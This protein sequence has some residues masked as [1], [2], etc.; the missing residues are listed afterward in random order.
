MSLQTFRMFHSVVVYCSL[1][2]VQ[3]HLAEAR[4]DHV[5]ASNIWLCCHKNIQKCP[6]VFLKML[7]FLM[8]HKHNWKIYKHLEKYRYINTLYLKFF[9]VSIL[10]FHSTDTPVL[11]L[12]F[13]YFYLKQQFVTCTMVVLQMTFTDSALRYCIW[14]AES[15][16]ICKAMQ[17][18]TAFHHWQREHVQIA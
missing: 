2:Q 4:K 6:D 9:K 14:S 3:K 16:C 12:L 5:L 10:L 13:F 8:P 1:D 15:T 11:A 17:T 7:T 18:L